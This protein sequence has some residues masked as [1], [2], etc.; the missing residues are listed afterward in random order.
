MLS[1]G[2]RMLAFSSYIKWGL[3]LTAM[4]GLLISVASLVVAHRL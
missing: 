4:Q 3:L 1:L 2:C